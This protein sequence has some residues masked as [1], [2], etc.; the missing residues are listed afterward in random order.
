L[1][2]HQ[3]ENAMNGN[4]Q[5]ERLSAYF[6][7][8]L[9][10]DERAM[11]EQELATSVDLR[12][13]IGEYSQLSGLLRSLP[14]TPAPVE[15]KASILR[16]IERESLLPVADT[17]RPRRLGRLFYSTTAAACAVAAVAFFAMKSRDGDHVAQNQR[18]APQIVQ[19][20]RQASDRLA[21]KVQQD[22]L[23]FSRDDLKNAQV[24]DVVNAVTKSG[25]AVSVIRLTVVGR[26]HDIGELRVLLA[27]SEST[28]RANSQ[29][30]MADGEVVAVYVQAEATDF[31]KSLADVIARFEFDS[32]SVSEP[33]S[34]EQ[35]DAEQQKLIAGS[36][37][38]VE[39]VT[40]KPGS[41][42]EQAVNGTAASKAADSTPS[43]GP[44]RVLFVLMTKS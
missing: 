8:Q 10:L 2:T 39:T 5:N 25:N 15:L 30:P 19:G 21:N 16:A 7:N 13:E 29:S 4:P 11:V 9:P 32:M 33:V 40:V 36:S 41:A 17:A 43:E 1:T 27:G 14:R 20:N 28:H 18:N 22:R 38:K 23:Q 6:D 37:R 12:Q 34:A 35:L 26:E 24:G 3:I 31:S 42:L 44:A